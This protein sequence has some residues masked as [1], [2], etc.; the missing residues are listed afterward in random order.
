MISED[1]PDHL[2]GG[3]GKT[4]AIL[5]RDRENERIKE[6]LEAGAIK[7]AEQNCKVCQS[8][9]TH[10][11]I[12]RNMG[13]KEGW[14]SMPLCGQ[15]GYNVLLTKSVDLLSCKKCYKKLALVKRD[16]PV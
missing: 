8:K 12:D 11:V 15:R 13:F 16:K 14:R 6:E 1:M 2:I 3:T 5:W 4:P 7:H 9:P 10:W